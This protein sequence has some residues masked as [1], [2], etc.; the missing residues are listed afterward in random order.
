MG[1]THELETQHGDCRTFELQTPHGE[2]SVRIS[3]SLNTDGSRT[4]PSSP[5]SIEERIDFFHG[6]MER[7]ARRYGGECVGA[8][9]FHY[10]GEAQGAVTYFIASKWHR[11]YELSVRSARGTV[12]AAIQFAF[13]GTFQ[14]FCRVAH[15]MDKLVISARVSETA[16]GE[17]K[18][19]SA[20]RLLSLEEQE[21]L[22]ARREAM[23]LR[24]LRRFDDA[25]EW[26]QKAY[27]I[28]RALGEVQ[29]QCNVLCSLAETTGHPHEIGLLIGKI[30]G[31]IEVMDDTEERETSLRKLEELKKSVG[32]L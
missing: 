7:F 11:V 13:T 28:Y 8:H 25:Y 1:R 9:L 31:L 4:F 20:F 24:I 32:S 18:S 17:M 6:I 10:L 23:K 26:Y 5:L 15:I 3:G 30:Q 19:E 14:S 27:S 22:A 29:E 21:A 12:T 2:L 16:A